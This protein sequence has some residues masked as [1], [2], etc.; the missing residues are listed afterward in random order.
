MV[1]SAFSP[2]VSEFVLLTKYFETR[3]K[4]KVASM[5]FKVSKIKTQKQIIF[6]EMTDY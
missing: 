3:E 5:T 1:N 4:L 6:F 2:F